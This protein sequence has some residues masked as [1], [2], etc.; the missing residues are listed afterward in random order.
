MCTGGVHIVYNILVYILFYGCFSLSLIY[1]AVE[2]THLA[3]ILYCRSVYFHFT[4]QHTTNTYS[5]GMK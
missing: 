5:D 2:E 1:S 3:S 4:R